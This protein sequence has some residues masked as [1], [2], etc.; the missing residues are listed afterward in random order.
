MNRHGPE[1]NCYTHISLF[2]RPFFSRVHVVTLRTP[3]DSCGSG[4]AKPGTLTFFTGKPP[5]KSQVWGQSSLWQRHIT[6]SSF[7]ACS[8]MRLNLELLNFSYHFL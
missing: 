7:Q 5:A 6:N 8:R 1:Y 4:T 2:G 3:T